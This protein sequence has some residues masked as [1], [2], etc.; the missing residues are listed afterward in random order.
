MVPLWKDW[1]PWNIFFK[2][3]LK[4]MDPME[5][6]FQRTVEKYGPHGTRFQVRRHLQNTSTGLVA[7]NRCRPS[8]LLFLDSGKHSNLFLRKQFFRCFLI[9]DCS[10]F[11]RCGSS[12]PQRAVALAIANKPQSDPPLWCW[13]S[14]KRIWNC[15]S[16]VRR[17]AANC[18]WSDYD[19]I[20]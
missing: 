11:C 10:K 4:N 7:T 1:T 5:L 19:P 2:R 8:L 20:E 16:C 18:K 3:Q 17:M 15:G 12:P 14:T 9:F 6:I 13:T